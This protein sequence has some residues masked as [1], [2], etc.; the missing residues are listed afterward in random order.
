MKVEI[1][2]Q[3]V[4]FLRRLPPEPRHKLRRA[5]KALTKESGDIKRLEGPLEDYCRLR[6]DGFRVIL[7]YT[8]RGSIQCVFAERR[9]IVYE[10]FAATLRSVVSGSSE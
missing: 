4:D 9:N 6:V 3:V 10:V 8:G 1:S 5:L 7:Y 2:S